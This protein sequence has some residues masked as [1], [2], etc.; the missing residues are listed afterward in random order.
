MQSPRAITA[1]KE[2]FRSTSSYFCEHQH[3]RSRPRGSLW[4]R[5]LATTALVGV[6]WP[7]AGHGVEIREGN[8]DLLRSEFL[9]K[10]FTNFD[11]LL[12]SLEQQ[13]SEAAKD[14]RLE[15]S[16]FLVSTLHYPSAKVGYDQKLSRVG[17]AF[18][19]TVSRMVEPWRPGCE[20]FVGDLAQTF[21][22]AALGSEAVHLDPQ[23]REAGV[24]AFFSQHLGPQLS[25][26]TV[27]TSSLQPLIDAIVI[28]A[29]FSVERTD[30]KGLVYSRQ[31]ALDVRTGR[32]SYFEHTY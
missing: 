2:L 3:R 20:R 27:P 23:L 16:I 14:F 18:P 15:K 10:P 4:R 19:I 9:S 30:K 22:L 24:R 17:I 29:T 6:V 21:G 7:L 11:Q 32:T 31:C 28:V 8:V 1:G 13:A 12:Y 25:I 5:L 26:D